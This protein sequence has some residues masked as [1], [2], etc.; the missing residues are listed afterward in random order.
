MVI[1]YDLSNND[2][3]RT[4]DNTITPMLPA[5]MSFDE[6]VEFYKSKGVGVI[7]FPDELGSNIY[8]Y[9]IKFSNKGKFIG[10]TTKSN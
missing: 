1:Y 10:L 2:I 8:D 6:K 5:N 3:L 4:E 7:T 9:E